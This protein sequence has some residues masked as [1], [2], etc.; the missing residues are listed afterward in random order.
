MSLV[1][2]SDSVDRDTTNLPSDVV[3]IS[4]MLVAIRLDRG[5]AHER[6]G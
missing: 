1:V 3:I 5:D 6:R 2:I 4:A